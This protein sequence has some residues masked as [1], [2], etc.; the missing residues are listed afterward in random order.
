MSEILRLAREAREQSKIAGYPL[1]TRSPA[2]DV[3]AVTVGRRCAAPCS[4]A[5]GCLDEG[6][7]F[8][9]SNVAY[10]GI[11]NVTWLA[12]KLQVPLH[13]GLKSMQRSHLLHQVS[14]LHL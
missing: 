10:S 9:L 5:V 7:R 14:H 6:G 2:L 13:L 1:A 4:A 8:S 11:M 3:F 12:E